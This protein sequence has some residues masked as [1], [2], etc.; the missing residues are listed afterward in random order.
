MNS[1]LETLTRYQDALRREDIE[2]AAALLYRD[3]AED[4]PLLA[5]AGSQ[6][7]KR[8]VGNTHDARRARLAGELPALSAWWRRAEVLEST[9]RV[10]LD[11]QA[12]E[13]YQFVRH[14]DMPVPEWRVS[15]LRRTDGT[16]AVVETRR[17]NDE[18][19]LVY[20]PAAVEFDP[21]R[22]AL[23]YRR[24]FG[25][26][27]VVTGEQIQWPN[28]CRAALRYHA[29]DDS[30]VRYEYLGSEV[31]AALRR[32]PRI[33]EFSVLL[34]DNFDYRL[35]QLV[36]ASRALCV[37]ARLGYPLVYLALANVAEPAA[38]V[39]RTLSNPTRD[40][41]KL[42][43]FWVGFHSD[44]EFAYSR[45]LSYF[46]L[47]EVEVPIDPLGRDTAQALCMNT[48]ILLLRE[49]GVLR[50]G[51]TV[52]AGATPEWRI[53]RGRRGPTPEETYGRYGSLQ[54]VQV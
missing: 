8:L 39:I 14:P 53:V 54:F 23:E 47:A 36:A 32:K 19:V 26:S 43:A 31:C 13:I 35:D 17:A 20:L 22:W 2:D 41:E 4:H 27:I 1:P 38:D 42:G 46:A 10:V 25:E 18:S 29:W 49:G 44:A 28:G 37:F 12:V 45:G 7:K 48:G 33:L 50:P 9:A 11:E 30:F 5:V 51:D 3:P 21:V 15:L 16:W 52:G 24:L 6:S 40:P 34:E